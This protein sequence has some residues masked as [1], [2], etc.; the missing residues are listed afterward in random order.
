L[1]AGFAL[2]H[3]FSIDDETVGVIEYFRIPVG[4]GSGTDQL[5]SFRDQAP[6]PLNLMPRVPVCREHR[7]RVPQCFEVSQFHQA[8]IGYC[9]LLF[10]RIRQQQEP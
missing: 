8:S 3:I 1:A 5:R 7:R 10:F 6:E 4:R 2:A 9:L